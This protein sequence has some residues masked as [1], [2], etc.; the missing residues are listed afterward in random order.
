MTPDEMVKIFR[1]LIFPDLRHYRRRTQ[2]HRPPHLGFS[3]QTI[4]VSVASTA[5]FKATP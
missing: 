3:Y 2:L 1:F 5:T 4:N